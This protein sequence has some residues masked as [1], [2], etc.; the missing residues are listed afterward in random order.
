[1][2]PLAAAVAFAAAVVLVVT[3]EADQAMSGLESGSSGV[4]VQSDMLKTEAAT[5]GRVS[6]GAT[7]PEGCTSR[8]SSLTMLLVAMAVIA[9]QRSRT[10]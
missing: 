3:V 1:M 2:G 7:A 9:R 10:A 5:G 4:V 8:A 6:D